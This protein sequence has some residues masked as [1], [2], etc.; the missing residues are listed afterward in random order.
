MPKQTFDHRLLQDCKF[1]VIDPAMAEQ[2]PDGVSG[3]RLVP[4]AFA[5]SAHLMPTLLELNTLSSAQSAALLQAQ[6]DAQRLD[7]PPSVALF[8]ETQ[9]DAESYTHH[10]NTMQLRRSWP[11]GP[12]WLRIHD[13]RVLHQLLR[14]LTLGQQIQLFGPSMALTYWLGGEWL[15][16]EKPTTTTH[17]ETA[18]SWDWP[19]I[20]RIGLVN[21]SLARAGVR[22]LSALSAQAARA[23]QLMVRATTEHGLSHPDD[24]V[25]FAYRGLGCT[26]KFDQHPRI[27]ALLHT[28]RDDEDSLLADRWALIEPEVWS[29]VTTPRAS[30]EQGVL[31]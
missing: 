11:A 4:P 19:R 9:A 31:S 28:S 23:E 16:A 30:K 7:E 1:A 3:M 2:L 21:R 18:S 20:E 6:D 26:P 15:R 17:T 14:V 5:S 13:T 29:A 12:T 25:E 24:L 10:W 22:S 27:K 8:V